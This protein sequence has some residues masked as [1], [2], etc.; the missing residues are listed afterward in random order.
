MAEPAARAGQDAFRMAGSEIGIEAQ[1]QKSRAEP[2]DISSDC[3]SNQENAY[4][5][6]FSP[7]PRI[8]R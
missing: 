2:R 6:A 7:C 5:I 8:I 3:E 4:R 1:R